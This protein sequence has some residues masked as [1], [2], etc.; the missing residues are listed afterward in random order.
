MCLS[1]LIACA[2][3]AHLKKTYVQRN[4]L[5]PGT[6]QTQLDESRRWHMGLFVVNVSIDTPQ[7]FCYLI[8]LREHFFMLLALIFMGLILLSPRLNTALIVEID[9]FLHVPHDR[10]PFGT[11]FLMLL[12]LLIDPRHDPDKDAPKDKEQDADDGAGDSPL[13]PV[14]VR[15]KIL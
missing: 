2:K 15:H 11:L 10:E 5:P 7:S 12:G 1:W 13:C 6:G 4:H 3:K 14:K 9:G 8:H